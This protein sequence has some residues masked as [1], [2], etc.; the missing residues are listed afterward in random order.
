SGWAVKSSRKAVSSGRG[1][2]SRF[3]RAPLFTAA[4]AAP[5]AAS[6]SARLGPMRISSTSAM[7]CHPGRGVGGGPVPPGAAGGLERQTLSARQAHALHRVG[8]SPKR[9]GSI[10]QKYVQGPEADDSRG[11]AGRQPAPV[12]GNGQ[13]VNRVL[14]PLQHGL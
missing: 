6:S 11:V 5:S 14:V 13:G 12:G 1:Q 10:I 2:A 7:F 4:T 9:A 3:L 8:P